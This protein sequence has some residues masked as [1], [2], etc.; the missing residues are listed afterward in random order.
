MES[1]SDVLRHTVSSASPWAVNL[2][3]LVLAGS[4]AA[5]VLGGLGTAVAIRFRDMIQAGATPRQVK[6]ILDEKINGGLSRIERKLDELDA[7]VDAE[8]EDSWRMH[9]ENGERLVKLE[10]LNLMAETGSAVARWDG[11]ERRRG[12]R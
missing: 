10:T 7:K 6:S 12:P 5:A 3:L 8:R 4:V 2:A 11:R 9:R 1:V